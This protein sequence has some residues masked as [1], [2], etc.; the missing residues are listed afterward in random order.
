ME[1]SYNKLLEIEEQMSLY[2]CWCNGISDNY[3]VDLCSYLTVIDFK[4]VKSFIGENPQITTQQWLTFINHIGT[5]DY[6]SPIIKIL[7]ITLKN[8]LNL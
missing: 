2:G 5:Y 6:L 4:K 8:D 1:T 7:I 3:P